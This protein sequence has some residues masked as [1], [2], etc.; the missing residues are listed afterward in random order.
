MAS[1]LKSV[2]QTVLGVAAFAAIAVGLALLVSVFLYGVPRVSLVVY[3]IASPL[4]GIA[5]AI[6]L[7]SLPFAFIK[8]AR[9]MVS[10]VLFVSSYLFGIILWTYSAGMVFV[11]W[12]YI[13]LLVGLIWLGVGVVPVAFLAASLHSDWVIVANILIGLFL[14][15]A[16][17]SSRGGVCQLVEKQRASGM[18]RVEQLK[19]QVTTTPLPIPVL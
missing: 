8:R 3:R 2:S 10:M 12:G 1:R 4:F 18:P 16:R 15:S 9:A 19:Y 17:D 14:T 5:L 13:G 7:S 6:D 11:F